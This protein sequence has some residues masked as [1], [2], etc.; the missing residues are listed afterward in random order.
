L[1]RITAHHIPALGEER[2]NVNVL[3]LFNIVNQH[4]LYRI[5]QKSW[6]NDYLSIDIGKSEKEE[7]RDQAEKLGE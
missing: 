1:I 7:S 2:S 5:R 6:G 4:I 3:F